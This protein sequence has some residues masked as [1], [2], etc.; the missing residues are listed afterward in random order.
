MKDALLI[1]L[2]YLAANRFPMASGRGYLEA[3]AAFLLPA[4]LFAALARGRRLGWAYLGL[5][6]GTA[7]GFH[8]VPEVM[9][10]KAPMPMA[11]ALGVGLLFFAY[12]ALG[13]L[14]V[15][16]LAR[17]AWGRR[18]LAGAL[19]AGLGMALWQTWAF[20]IYD[21][22]YASPLGAVPWMARSAAFLGAQ[23]L[24]ALLWGL[25]A[26]TGFQAARGAGPRRIL[27]GPALL[28]LLLGSLD[29]AWHYLPRGPQRALDVVMIQP[30]YP[31]GERMPG[32]EADMWRRT[33]AELRRAGLPRPGFATL[34]LWPES[35]VLGR[36]DRAPGGRL[37]REAQDRGVAWLYGTEGGRFNLVRGEAAGQPS[38]I[39]AKVVPMPFGE[40]MPGPPPV[41][42]FLDRHLD[43]YSA[44][45]GVLGPGSSFRFPTPQGPL[46]VHPLIC[47]EALLEQRVADG[48]ALAGGDL[49][50]N[51]TNDG[52][53]DRSVATDLHA[54]QIRLRAV[55]AG[56][57]LL[58][59]TLT[60]KSGLFRADGSWELWGQ[61]MTEA[62]RSLHLVWRP[63][64]TPA[65][66]PW[67]APGIL[68]LLTLAFVLAAWNKRDPRLN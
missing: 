49:L 42:D 36:D 6:A 28:L 3:C 63:I 48:L 27:A 13:I 19:A 45:A 7:G 4:L 16:A 39:Q 2:A 66:H 22:S 12:E 10:S 40:R 25:G 21:L 59:A 33:D 65:R 35:S 58:R 44:E 51:L 68:A 50:A 62:S 9:H 55:E 17:W 31:P 46:T 5:L 30:N 32:M 24:V 60:G 43:F 26:W 37:S 34:V 23:G 1:A 29:A 67:L 61:P 47:S 15:A 53:F 8:W 56:L 52:W 11:A 14:A 57:P 54:V 64:A 41:R 20:H 18:P 38:F